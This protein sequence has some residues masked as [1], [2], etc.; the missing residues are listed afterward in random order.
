MRESVPEVFVTAAVHVNPPRLTSPFGRRY[1]QI[2]SGAA[3]LTLGGSRDGLRNGQRSFPAGGSGSQN[4]LLPQ[5]NGGND[6][7]T[8]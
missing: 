4:D 3:T 8:F 1:K 2:V 6:E 5:L 7:I